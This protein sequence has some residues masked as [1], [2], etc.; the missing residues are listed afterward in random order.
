V[1]YTA[2]SENTTPLSKLLLRFEDP[3][4]AL[5][6]SH[7]KA[8]M[9]GMELVKLHVSGESSERVNLMFM[10]DGCTSNLLRQI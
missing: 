2:L 10:A 3:P 8:P 1:N 7:G 4:E 9:K 6:S 5:D